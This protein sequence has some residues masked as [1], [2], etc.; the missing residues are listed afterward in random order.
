MIGS[1]SFEVDE[2]VESLVDV[3]CEGVSGKRLVLSAL[4]TL[5]V[6]TGSGLR[7][8]LAGKK[9]LVMRPVESWYRSRRTMPLSRHS[10]TMSLSRPLVLQPSLFENTMSPGLKL[11]AGS[12]TTGCVRCRR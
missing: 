2:S 10:R 7:R 5:G 3:G 6:T 8:S 9:A 4:S 11:G 12:Q 1:G